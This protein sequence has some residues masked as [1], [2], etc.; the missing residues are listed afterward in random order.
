MAGDITRETES[1][2]CYIEDAGLAAAV[3]AEVDTVMHCGASVNFQ[4]P[5]KDAFE[6]NVY[7][8]MRVLQLGRECVN[9]RAHVH[10]STCY[11]NCTR[12]GYIGEH[13]YPYA[14]SKITVDQMVD[15][16]QRLTPAE[17]AAREDE[18]LYPFPNTVR[19]LPPVWRACWR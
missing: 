13:V 11:V 8:A 5:L 15:L 1:G 3:R 18:L 17:L 14:N 10:I 2:A 6:V 12:S 4:S 7:G 9:L 19:S 16:V